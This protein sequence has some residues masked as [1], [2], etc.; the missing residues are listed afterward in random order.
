MENSIYVALSKQVAL[1]QSMQIVSNNVA[2]MNT[3]G[4]R[5]QNMI[6]EEYVS[7]PRGYNEPLS[8]VLD[9]GQYQIT[10]SGPIKYTGNNL[11]VAL[12]GP[13][14]LGVQT[15]EG[16]QF[17]RA[18]NM[19]LNAN[20]ELVNSRGFVMAGQG[21]GAITIPP[22]AEEIRIDENGF[23]STDDGE[24]G[25]LMVMEFDSEQ[26]LNPAGN[27][28]YVLPEDAAGVPAVQT[29]V[30]QGQLEGANIQGV[31]EMTRM[32]KIHREYE[33]LQRFMQSEHERQRT[34]IQRLMRNGGSA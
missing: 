10:D 13:G 27:G 11:D 14:F 17:T 12:I 2:N 21:G 5:G 33:S 3:P 29:K 24:V 18:G 20:G 30:K 15:P 23:V 28:L 9:Y 26:T 25:Q 7:K 22:D 4:Y 16:V 32:I 8:M 1:R 6:F 19:S 31:V 34:A